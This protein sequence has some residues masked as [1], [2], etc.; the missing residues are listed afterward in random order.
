MGIRFFIA[1][2]DNS[3][4]DGAF[5]C[6]CVLNRN[7]DSLGDVAVLPTILPVSSEKK[8]CGGIS[9]CHTG[10]PSL[11]GDVTSFTSKFLSKGVMLA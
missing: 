10:V 9:V 5:T 3:S 6:G 2:P 8:F 4:G 11:L 7:G 1:L